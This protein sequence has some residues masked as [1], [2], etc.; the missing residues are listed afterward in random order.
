MKKRANRQL[1]KYSIFACHLFPF[2]L[3]I[4]MEHWVQNGNFVRDPSELNR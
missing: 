1:F 2:L 3:D 4:E